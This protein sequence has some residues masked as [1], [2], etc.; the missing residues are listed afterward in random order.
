[1]QPPKSHWLNYPAAVDIWY[2]TNIIYVCIHIC[3]CTHMCVYIHIHI[4]ICIMSIYIFRSCRGSMRWQRMPHFGI[5]FWNPF[6]HRFSEPLFSHLWNKEGQPHSLHWAIVIIKKYVLF[7]VIQLCLPLCRPPWTVAHQ[8]PLSMGNLQARILE[9]VVM[10]SSR[11]SSQPRDQTQVSYI[12]ADSLPS[13]LPG[14][15]IKK[16]NMY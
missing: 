7:L 2:D 3:I 5:L 4:H 9:W 11:G 16:Y 14:N 1:M 13:E 15:P 6:L 8:A 10:P 12:A